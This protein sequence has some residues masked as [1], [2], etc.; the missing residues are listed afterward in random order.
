MPIYQQLVN[1]TE[2]FHQLRE[3]PIIINDLP[4]S[5]EEERDY[6]TQLITTHYNSDML[7][8]LP[9]CRCGKTK[10]EYEIGSLCAYCKT[11]VKSHISEDIEP[12]VWFRRPIG[13]APLINPHIYIMLRNRFRRSGFEVLDWLTDT[14]FSTNSKQPAVLKT[15]LNAGVQ[16]GYNNFINNFDFIMGVMFSIKDYKLKKGKRD[17]LRELIALNRGQLFSDYIPLPNKSLLVIENNN[18]GRYADNSMVMAID[19]IRMI[20]SI[21]RRFSEHNVILRE[22]RTAKAI[23]RLGDF[24]EAFVSKNMSP[25]PGLFRKHIFGSRSHFSFRAVITSLTDRHAYDEIH[26]PWGIGVTVL[27]DHLLAKMMRMG[28]ALNDAIGMLHGHVHNYNE[29]LD[30]L[31]KEII[32]ESP[33]SSLIAILQRNE[34]Q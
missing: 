7:S 21:D 34:K 29:M 28:Y 19:V 8:I 26:V 13:V 30:Q 2:M 9:S 11:P 12:L 20:T 14:T 18:L 1:F 3:P 16:R 24:Y 6:I 17:Y 33:D 25:K 4:N 31:L 15:I 27:R 22:N 5:T 32:A 10:G 23:T